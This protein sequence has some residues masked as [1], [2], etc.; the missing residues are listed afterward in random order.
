MRSTAVFAALI[1]ALAAAPAGAQPGP[2]AAAQ[3]LHQTL[4]AYSTSDTPIGVLL[5]DPASR[6]ILDRHIPHFSTG[7][8]LAMIRQATLRQIQGYAL[9]VLSDPVLAA[10]DAD[11]AKLPPKP[12]TVVSRTT[13]DEGK[14]RPYVLPDPLKLSNGEPVRDAATWQRR[15][16]PQI[17]AMFESLEYGRA[18]GRPSDE[19]FEVFDKGTPAFGGKALRKQVLIHLSKDPSS[20]AIHL[21]EYLPAEAKRPV[22]VF[23]MIGFT[24][25][26]AMFDDPGLRPGLVWDPA[27]KRKVPASGAAF[28]FGRAQDFLDAGFAVAAFY[29]GDVDPDFV[30]GYPLGIRAAYDK[31]DEARRAPD[32]WG[33]IGA[34]AWGLSRVQD[35]L[36]TDPAVDARRVA[37]YGA[38]RL[39]KT[40]LWAAASDQRFAAAIA[41]CSGKM[42][43]GLMHRNFG[44]SIRGD[45]G[46][47]DYWVAPNFRRF[48]DHEEALPID[49]HMLLALIA[50]RPVLLQTGAYDHAADPKGE[51]LAEVAAGPVYRLLGAQDLGT[52][53]WPPEAPILNDLGY[54]M[55]GGGHGPAPGDWDI[56]LAFLRKHLKPKG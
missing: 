17:L 31:V 23:L 36:E 22:P 39:G 35:Y 20:P 5:D 42:G 15:R 8:Q 18:P 34:W 28:R 19:R 26:S 48:Y 16:R 33:A 41:C 11:L 47:A 43:A 12:V 38:S 54:T 13:T 46:G 44:A 3:T 52:A 4:Q 27:T 49:G 53:T 14:V 10:I 51:F 25:P 56:Y 45:D 32:A 21:V 6:A 2:G 7:P 37:V 30:G 9:K 50:P 29:Y 40:A 1:L 24:A 55:N